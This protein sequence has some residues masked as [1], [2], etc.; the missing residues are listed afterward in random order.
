MCFRE[1]ERKFL[2]IIKLFQCELNLK[3][4]LKGALDDQNP[5]TYLKRELK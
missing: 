4:M 1:A 3:V 2:I 5:V